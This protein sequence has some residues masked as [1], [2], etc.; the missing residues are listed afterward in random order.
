MLPSALPEIL[1]G[2]CLGIGYAWRAIISAEL[3]AATSGIGYMILD[4]RAMAR[5]DKVI[6]GVLVIAILGVTTDFLTQK[7]VKFVTRNR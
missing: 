1:L 4:A 6:V 3:I 7:L 5:T 2:L